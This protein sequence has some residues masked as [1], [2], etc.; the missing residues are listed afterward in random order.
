MDAAEILTLERAYWQAIQEGDAEAIGRLTDD[1]CVIVGEQGVSQ[2]DREAIVAMIGQ[3]N[4][5][6][7][8]FEIG[9]NVEVAEAG[10]GA[11]VIGYRVH[12]VLD[13]GG[14]TEKLEAMDS[15]VWVRRGDGWRCALHTETVVPKA[16]TRKRA[17]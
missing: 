3:T 16:R 11:A 10:D 8:S 5:T 7:K 14:K 15:S 9:P 4:Y 2:F 12:E 17:A 13:R 1:H 6:L